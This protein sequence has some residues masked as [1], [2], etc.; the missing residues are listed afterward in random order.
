MILEKVKLKTNTIGL[1]R[2]DMFINIYSIKEA[3]TK[4]DAFFI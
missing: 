3:S 2:F 4:F 1:K